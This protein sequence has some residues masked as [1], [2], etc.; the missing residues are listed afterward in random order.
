MQG[1]ARI[2][3]TGYHIG[4]ISGGR[5]PETEIYIR[6]DTG[7]KNGSPDMGS[8][9]IFGPCIVRPYIYSH[10]SS[11]MYIQSNNG[12]RKIKRKEC[13]SNYITKRCNS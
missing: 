7:Y 11:M 10:A 3:R 5:I 8:I 9:P 1:E 6:P 4:W 13:L 12:C 2:G